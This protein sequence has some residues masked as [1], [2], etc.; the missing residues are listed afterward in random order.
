MSNFSL[1][2]Q[3]KQLLAGYEFPDR[4]ALLDS[5]QPVLT[6]IEKILLDRVFLAWMERLER[7]IAINAGCVE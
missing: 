3:V 7:C 5:V 1:F 6:G 2:V 4:G